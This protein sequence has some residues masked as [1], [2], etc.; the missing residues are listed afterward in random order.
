M[1]P[2]LAGEFRSALG[3][4]GNHVKASVSQLAALV[5]PGIEVPA[6]SV[7][8]SDAEVV[9]VQTCPVGAPGADDVVSA[10]RA[11][12]ERVDFAVRSND[13]ASVCCLTQLSVAVKCRLKPVRVEAI[14]GSESPE[15]CI[16]TRRLGAEHEGAGR[17]DW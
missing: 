9:R 14:V 3:W 5:V 12:K 1:Q 11:V 15:S 17:E 16:Q 8:A 6:G 4:I 7:L 13:I 10:K 2:Q